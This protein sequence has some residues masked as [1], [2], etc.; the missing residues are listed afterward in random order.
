MSAVGNTTFSAVLRLDP[1]WVSDWSCSTSRLGLSSVKATAAGAVKMAFSV[2][3]ITEATS[4]ANR[5]L[6]LT[7]SFIVVGGGRDV[8]L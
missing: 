6:R 2:F 3:A 5:Q 4:R 8:A 1:L 7:G